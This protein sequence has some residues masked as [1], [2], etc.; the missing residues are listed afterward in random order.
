WGA[1]HVIARRVS[2]ARDPLRPTDVL[3]ATIFALGE[4]YFGG[5][6]FVEE[7]RT[8]S[9]LSPESGEFGSRV[10]GWI[11]RLI[12]GCSAGVGVLVS[13]GCGGSTPGSTVSV[14]PQEREPIYGAAV[15]IGKTLPPIPPR[16][17]RRRNALLRHLTCARAEAPL[18]R[19]RDRP[20]L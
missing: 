9:E 17:L 2:F 8:A 12:A 20:R 18:R 13:M 14:V 1:R 4:K 10:V 16:A 19:L 3:P 6:S 5:R 7:L 15:V 11:G